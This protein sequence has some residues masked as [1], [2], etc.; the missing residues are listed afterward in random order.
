M[1][2]WAKRDEDADAWWRIY[3]PAFPINQVFLLFQVVFVVVIRG[4]G[5]YGGYML[6]DKVLSRMYTLSIIV[7]AKSLC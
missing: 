3:V 6:L 1:R 4:V 2:T 7:T 5:E